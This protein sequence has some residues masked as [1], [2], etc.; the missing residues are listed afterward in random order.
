MDH[1]AGSRSRSRSPK[2]RASNQP[3]TS[4]SDP[5]GSSHV[6]HVLILPLKQDS[7][8]SDWNSDATQEYTHL[9]Q[10]SEEARELSTSTPTEMEHHYYMMPDSSH[11]ISWNGSQPPSPNPG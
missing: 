1:P 4:S 9:P 2:D 5:Q 6:P 10:R 11:T 7:D 8:D 3:G